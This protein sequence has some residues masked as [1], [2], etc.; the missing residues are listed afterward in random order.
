[1]CRMYC[2]YVFLFHYMCRMYCM[3]VF[4]FHYMNRMYCMFCIARLSKSI[5]YTFYIV[6]INK[7]PFCC[8]IWVV[9]YTSALSRITTLAYS[10]LCMDPW[11]FG[12][13]THS[14][15]PLT[16]VCVQNRG[17]AHVDRVMKTPQYNATSA[18]LSTPMKIGPQFGAFYFDGFLITATWLGLAL[19]HHMKS[20]WLAPLIHER[21]PR[22]DVSTFWRCVPCSFD[23][24]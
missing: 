1:M 21:K 3:Y 18:S 2:M 7:R 10:I 9:S 5:R 8:I 14:F 4:L 23:C 12:V 22:W 13:T 19:P 17:L 16:N 6:T 24:I 11:C 15:S 20:Q